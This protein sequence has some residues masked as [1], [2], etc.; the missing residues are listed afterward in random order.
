M[1]SSK[2]L[3]VNI[4]HIATIRNARNS[5]YP[6]LLRAVALVKKAGAEIVTVH[7]REDRRHIRDNDAFAICNAGILPVNLEIA[8][9]EEML[10]IALKLK[11]KYVCF[12]PEKREE[13]TTEGGLNILLH[14]NVLKDYTLK[15][16]EN[17]TEVSFFIE[18]SFEMMDLALECGANTVEIHT[19]KFADFKEEKEFERVKTASSYAKS[20]GLNVH[21]GHGLTFETAVKI[22]EISEISILHI[23]HFLITESIF[24]GLEKAVSEMKT[25]IN[26]V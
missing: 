22:S 1:K 26:L 3:S 23:G 10:E 2:I 9:T 4:D 18:A 11:P 24:V 8:A 6:D 12:V 14:K 5:P 20:K 17:G 13:V 25:K 19:G 16:K 15:L 21:A 7:L